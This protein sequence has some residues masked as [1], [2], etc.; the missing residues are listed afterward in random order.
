M[1]GEA[2]THGAP[3]QAAIALAGGIIAKQL[4]DIPRRGCDAKESR[5]HP[6][7]PVRLRTTREENAHGIDQ[8][9][10]AGSTLRN[11]DRRSGVWAFGAVLY[12]MLAGRRAFQGEDIFPDYDEDASRRPSRV[13]SRLVEQNPRAREWP[14]PLHV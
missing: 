10:L 9:D 12:E 4:R 8:M 13:T 7:G 11:A 5:Q 2:A 1:V 6:V 14:D 3:F